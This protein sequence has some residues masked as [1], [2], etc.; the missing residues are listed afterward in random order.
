MEKEFSK[1]TEQI[2]DNGK[3]VETAVIHQ[4]ISERCALCRLVDDYLVE[5]KVKEGDD[6]EEKRVGCSVIKMLK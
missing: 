6:L 5:T 4:I 1:F 3:F 2:V